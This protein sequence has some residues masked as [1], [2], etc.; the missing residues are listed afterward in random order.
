MNLYESRTSKGFQS[1]KDSISPTNKNK[2]YAQDDQDSGN[3]NDRELI[4]GNIENNKSLN[5]K[6]ANE[7]LKSQ[8][9]SILKHERRLFSPPRYL[10][11]TFH[12][13]K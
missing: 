8:A 3:L 1:L 7:R 13:L 6:Q 4:T 5:L 9:K 10:I 12:F 2:F 11:L